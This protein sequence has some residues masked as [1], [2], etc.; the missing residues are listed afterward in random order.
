M[1]PLIALIQD[2]RTVIV[3]DNAVRLV[4]VH[5]SKG[6]QYPVVFAAFVWKNAELKHGGEEQ[7]FFHD[8]A[9]GQKLVRD[10]G[11]EISD[12]HKNLAME[13]RLA[14]NVRL[15]Y[16]A[17]TRARNRCYFVWGGLK[18]AEASAPAWLLHPPPVAGG[19][20]PVAA[21]EA[22]FSV[23]IEGRDILPENFCSV[24]AIDALLKSHGASL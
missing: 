10:L 1:T 9:R 18:N 14:E 22:N 8:P 20:S 3:D 24:Q 16:V 23:C 17:L 4:T 21:L 5:K 13:E 7:V 15:L 2:P 11:P 12:A 19:G 6:L